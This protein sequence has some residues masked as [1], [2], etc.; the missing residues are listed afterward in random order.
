M[1]THS[2]SACAHCNAAGLLPKVQ[3]VPGAFSPEATTPNLN[4]GHLGGVL[5]AAAGR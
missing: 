4:K 1:T 5:I 2:S 3:A